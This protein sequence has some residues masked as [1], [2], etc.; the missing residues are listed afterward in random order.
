MRAQKVETPLHMASRAGHYEVAEF[1]LQNAAPVD[2]KA[3]VDVT[4]T[5]S[6]P[7]T[8]GD[9]FRPLQHVHT[10][11]READQLMKV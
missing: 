4:F 7:S 8:R 6:P 1:L 9:T 10:I 2:A 3:K 11:K 5:R